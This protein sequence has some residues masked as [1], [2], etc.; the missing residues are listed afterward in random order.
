MIEW[1][2]NVLDTLKT[3]PKDFENLKSNIDKFRCNYQML[4][5]SVK[6]NIGTWYIF[7]KKSIFS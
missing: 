5:K 3:I 7:I 4:L 6:K 2:G 1:D